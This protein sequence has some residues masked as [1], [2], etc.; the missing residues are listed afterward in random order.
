M[1]SQPVICA[2]C[3][4]ALN[5]F[6]GPDGATYIHPNDHPGDHEPVPVAA[7]PDWRG[8]CDFCSDDQP[9]HVVP[10]DDFRVPGM[11][12]QISDGGWAACAACTELVGADDWARLEDRVATSFDRVNGE[13][14][15]PL[16][17][18]YIREL[19]RRL[20]H[21]ITGPPVPLPAK[22]T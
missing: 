20:R 8:R 3:D 10:A 11:D 1:P 18:R 9:T 5:V 21:V 13:P 17:R 4:S 22:E 15:S 16:A 19:H 6:I 12:W 2:A 14:M 7:R